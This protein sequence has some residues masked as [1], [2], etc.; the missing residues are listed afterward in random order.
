VAK[1]KTGRQYLENSEERMIAEE[2]D[3]AIL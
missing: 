2:F 1:K 3:M